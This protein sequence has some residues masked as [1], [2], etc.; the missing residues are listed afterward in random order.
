MRAQKQY[1]V[2]VSPSRPDGVH[3]GPVCHLYDKLDIA[4]VVVVGAPRHLRP[5]KRHMSTRCSASLLHARS[6]PPSPSKAQA[7]EQL[8]A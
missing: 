5:H 4:I 7:H 6:M 2:G 3:I 8:G 1:Q